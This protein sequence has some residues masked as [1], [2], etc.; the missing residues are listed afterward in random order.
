MHEAVPV[1]AAAGS[2]VFVHVCA[3][4]MQCQKCESLLYLIK[5]V[6]GLQTLHKMFVDSKIDRST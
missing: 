2:I 1:A 5:H 6:I 3:A 4:K